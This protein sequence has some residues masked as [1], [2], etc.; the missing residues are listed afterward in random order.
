MKNSI[1]TKLLIGYFVFGILGIIAISTISS[2]VTLSYLE[3]HYG[4]NL[5]ERANLI[6]QD[7]RRFYTDGFSQST[8]QTLNGA[9][10]A[11]DADI[12]LVKADGWVSFDTAYRMT[13]LRLEDFDPSASGSQLYTIGSYADYYPAEHMITVS[14]PI[15]AN[16][17]TYGYVM[18]HQPVS[19]VHA[20]RDSVL[21]VQYII[22]LII[23]ALAFFILLLV[24][25]IVLKPLN[26]ISA[27]AM[28][29][30][31]GNLK[32]ELIL[33]SQ[34]EMGKLADTLNYMA[35]ELNNAEE[36]QRKFISNVSHDFRSPLT[37]IKGY[38]E[39]M[40]DGTIPPEMQGKYLNIVI[41]ETER[42]TALTR[43]TLELQSLQSRK[44]ALS[45]TRFDVNQIIRDTVASF[46]G[47]CKPRHIV[48][49]LI[50]H[51]ESIFVKADKLKIQQVL[52]NLLD[53]AIKFSHD[54]SSIM[55]ETSEKHGKV[56]VSVKDFGVG[57]P[58]DSIKKIWSRFYKTDSSRGKDK[59]GTGLGLSIVRE[60]I[61]A[62]GENIDV[63]STEDIGSEFIFSLPKA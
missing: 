15:T 23:F 46:E 61:V 43:S 26:K 59:K 20:A 55:I 33:H 31:Q 51:E 10:A 28:E 38:L 4:R 1:I 18:I 42:L 8:F 16:F 22:F 19:I 9:A 40:L 34:D 27:A 41:S 39:A 29:Y 57:I 17:T 54:S 35:H 50:F 37:S 53:N 45:P 49:E 14:V 21:E 48:L 11:L 12:W 2:R 6:A 60:I 63:I 32:Y 52:Y 58:R 5:Y 13:N 62:H 7:C 47:I 30:A 36:Y 24:R 56:F 3:D 25:I 44:M